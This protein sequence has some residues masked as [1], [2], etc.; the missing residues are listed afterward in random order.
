[1]QMGY[2]YNWW[3]NN[4][5]SK[6]PSRT[7]LT[8]LLAGLC[9]FRCVCS[10]LLRLN[11]CQVVRLRMDI[12]VRL[13]G[14]RSTQLLR[15]NLRS[16]WIRFRMRWTTRGRRFPCTF[17]SRCWCTRWSRFRRWF[18]AGQ[19]SIQAWR[20]FEQSFNYSRLRIEQKIL[21][22]SLLQYHGQLV[23]VEKVEHRVLKS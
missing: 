7:F 9:C 4:K 5:N 23:M 8:F 15:L 17:V 21:Q 14:R 2:M 10:L 13:G 16:A 11:R 3:T 22:L 1:M 20:R 12:I 18:G 6:L 19:C